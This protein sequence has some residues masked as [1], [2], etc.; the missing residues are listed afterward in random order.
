MKINHEALCIELRRWAIATKRETVAAEI[1]RF[2]FEL[3]GGD[4]P[5]YPLEAPGATHNNM[6]NIFR[7]LDSDS[8]KAREKIEILRPAI[9]KALEYRRSGSV[10][11]RV[12]RANKEFAKAVS[13]AL[14]DSPS[15]EKEISEAISALHALQKR[16]VYG[17]YCRV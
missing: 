6:Q 13:A 10:S 7:W 1:S 8:R 14:L 4:L 9:L 15:I 11:Y 17:N 12:A 5:L 16:P 3:G 2:Y